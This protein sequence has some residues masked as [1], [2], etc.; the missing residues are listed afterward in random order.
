M[1]KERGWWLGNQLDTMLKEGPSETVKVSGQ[2][3]IVDDKIVDQGDFLK[4][5][6]TIT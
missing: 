3:L 2:A 4:A 1:K 5:W 6:V